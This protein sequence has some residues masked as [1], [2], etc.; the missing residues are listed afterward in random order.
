MLGPVTGPEL[1]TCQITGP[2]AFPAGVGSVNVVLATIVSLLQLT[3][4]EKTR[5]AAPA[6]TVIAEQ[7]AEPP[8]PPP[9]PLTAVHVPVAP[10]AAPSQ[11]QTASVDTT[12]W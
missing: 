4:A 7:G 9:P 11:D 10:T 2:E 1:V 3:V 12:T 8:P 6:V 5:V